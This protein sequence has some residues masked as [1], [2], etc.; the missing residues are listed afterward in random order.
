MPEW[1]FASGVGLEFE[2]WGTSLDAIYS[3]ATWGTGFN[4]DV[5]PGTQSSRDG[6]I[7]ALLTFNLSGYYQINDQVKLLAGIQN[8]F[9]ER[10]VVS[11]IPEGPR[12][13]APR[14]VYA[15]FEAQF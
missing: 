12:A 13:N 14:M 2:K 3:G 6:K 7:D 15:G 9:D 11:R 4:D 5:R 10:G 1:K 8:L